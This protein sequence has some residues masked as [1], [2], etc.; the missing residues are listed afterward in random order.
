MTAK[1]ILYLIDTLNTGGTERSLLDIASRLNSQ[2]LAPVVCRAYSGDELQASFE[3]A[4]IPVVTLGLR[5]KYDLIRGALRFAR[6]VRQLRPSIVHTSLFRS[7][8]IGRLACKWTRTPVVSS[9]VNVSYEPSRLKEN[10]HLS[11]WKLEALRVVDRFSARWATRFHAVSE[12]VRDSNCRF[13][14]VPREKVD[15]VPRGR[16]VNDFASN[17]TPCPARMRAKLG[18]ESAFPVF[19]NVGR[20]IDQK[21]QSYLIRAMSMLSN[22]LPMAHLVLAGDG[23]NR[24]SLEQLTRE[25]GLASRVTF[26]GNRKD[27]PQLLSMCDIFVFPSL[28]EGLPGA[29]VEAMISGRP[30]IASDIAEIREVIEHGK[31]G[32]LVPPRDGHAWAS[33]MERLAADDISRASLGINAERV[34]NSRYDIEQVVRL[35]EAFY[36][37]SVS[38]RKTASTRPV[39]AESQ[40]E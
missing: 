19:L 33:A 37:E 23:W 40:C 29:L 16:V 1:T 17:A 34:G 27:V 18:L 22:R 26:L 4:G 5:G 15:V 2:E 24:G 6:L 31:T 8:Q 9:F 13:L 11:A 32:L 7:D 30:I 12:T 21:G 20:L 36:E 3:N 39:R 38:T 35:M 25:H 10:P 28:F 14:R